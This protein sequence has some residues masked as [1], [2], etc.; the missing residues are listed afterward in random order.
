M[1]V[2]RRGF[3]TPIGTVSYWADLRGRGHARALNHTRRHR[4]G[5]PGRW[6]CRL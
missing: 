6:R 3:P 2:N 5:R 4:C 1:R